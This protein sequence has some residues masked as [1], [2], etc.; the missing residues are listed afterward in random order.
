[1]QLV[2]ILFPRALGFHRTAAGVPGG[3]GLGELWGGGCLGEGMRAGERVALSGRGGWSQVGSEL[4]PSLS[5]LQ[6]RLH[7]KPQFC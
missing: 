5:G 4:P 3:E 2:Q 7:L 6:T 1:M